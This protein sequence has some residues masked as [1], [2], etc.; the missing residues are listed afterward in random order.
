MNNKRGLLFWRLV[1]VSMAG[2]LLLIIVTVI[3]VHLTEQP[4]FC[5]TCH[6]M[7]PY[8]QAWKTSK[9]NNVECVKC[10]F[11]PGVLSTIEGKFK[12]LS[13]VV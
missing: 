10:H 2:L 1:Q 13:M 8:Y 9:H 7:R 12:A 4:T 3:A 6:N 5:K 11:E